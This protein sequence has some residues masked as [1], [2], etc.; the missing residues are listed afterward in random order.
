MVV[1]DQKKKGLQKYHGITAGTVTPSKA[2]VV[3]SNKDLSSLRNLTLTGTLTVGSSNF[4]SSGST[5]VAPTLSGITAFAA[6][7][8]IDTDSGT[9]TA[10]GTGT[11]GSATINKMAGVVTT[12]TMTSTAGNTYTLTITNSTVAAADIVLVSFTSATTGLPV[13]GNVTPGSGAFTVTFTNISATIAL[14][15]V[16]V[17]SFLVLKA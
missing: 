5:F 16:A 11:T 8:T 14:N 7:A 2:L 9:A 4:K 3:D 6:G 13:L 12:T 1:A 10:T 17:V 15:A